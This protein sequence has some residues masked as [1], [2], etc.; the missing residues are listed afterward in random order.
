MSL[1][2]DQILD[3]AKEV[4]AVIEFSEDTLGKRTYNAVMKALKQ[5]YI[6]TRSGA[7]AKFYNL[8]CSHYKMPRMVFS[9]GTRWWDGVQLVNLPDECIEPL[10]EFWTADR[11]LYRMENQEEYNNAV[12][13]NGY[14]YS[15]IREAIQPPDYKKL[16]QQSRTNGYVHMRILNTKDVM[17]FDAIASKYINTQHYKDALE[18]ATKLMQGGTMTFKLKGG[19]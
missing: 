2:Q 18:Q 8:L 16:I 11:V 17:Y 14:L 3:M 1:S 12:A 4:T 5:G 10:S 19:V 7:A 9:R 6:P 15:G 13:S